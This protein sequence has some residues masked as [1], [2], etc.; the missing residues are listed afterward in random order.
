MP[1]V[2]E[3]NLI[4]VSWQLTI[5]SAKQPLLCF[6]ELDYGPSYRGRIAK[7]LTIETSRH[8]IIVE[9]TATGE[10][11][12]IEVVGGPLMKG[13]DAQIERLPA[14]KEHTGLRFVER[15]GRNRSNEEVVELAHND[16]SFQPKQP[17]L[18][19]TIGLEKRIFYLLESYGQV[20]AIKM[21]PCCTVYCDEAS[22]FSGMCFDFEHAKPAFR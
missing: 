21:T 19:V 17:P 5:P 11:L 22:R 20:R 15:I 3:S 10:P 7:T 9:M 2:V 1:C 6:V 14:A 8:D 12:Q 4:P 18:A 16:L 13:G